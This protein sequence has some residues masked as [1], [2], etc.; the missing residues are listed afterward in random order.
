MS[1]LISIIRKEFLHIVRD[2]RSLA[3]FVL[4]PVLQITIGAYVFSFDI[5]EVPVV[6]FDQDKGRWSRE[7]QTMFLQSQYFEVKGQA[8][9]LEEVRGMIDKG[10]A[11]I[12]IIVPPGF[13]RRVEVNQDASL[14]IIV[15]GSDPNAANIAL[16]YTKAM[17]RDI[18]Y[19]VVRSRIHLSI[20]EPVPLETSIVVRY[21]PEL[22]SRV[23]MLP[24]L[25]A[26]VMVLPALMTALSMV[27]EKERGTIEQLISTPL[28]PYE[29]VLGKITPYALISLVDV[30]LVSVVGV[31][32]FKIPFEGSPLLF[33]VLTLD[34]FFAFLGLSLLI[35]T[36]AKTQQEA[37]IVAA[38]LFN[39]PAIF[40]SGLIFPLASMPRVIQY[41]AQLVPTRYFVTIARGIFLKGARID[42]LWPE[43]I[44]L[45]VFGLVVVA[46]SSLR[47]RK[48]LG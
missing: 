25:V 28:K 10:E 29:L 37:T 16:G 44:F 15:D 14:Q 30:F 41:I 2:R 22:K 43:A 12:A 34:Y 18:S 36:L 35:S 9:S 32:G 3:L 6:I 17:I 7:V 5:Q 33:I 48:K 45:F 19:R 11:R 23:F 47:F 4:I 21:N 24:G 8:V 26:L 20:S 31:F 13:T 46:I 1:R 39:M 38:L 42:L 40:L 27:R